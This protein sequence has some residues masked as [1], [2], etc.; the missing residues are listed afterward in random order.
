MDSGG[1]TGLLRALSS[2][3]NLQRRKEHSLPGQP[4]PL[5]D[6][7][8]EWKN[9]SL[10]LIWTSLFILHTHPY[11]AL[12]I[13]WICLLDGFSLA[14]GWLLLG[15]PKDVPLPGRTSL[16][17]QPLPK[18]QVIQSPDFLGNL[19]PYSLQFIS[20]FPVLRCLKQRLPIPDV[21][22]QVLR[23]GSW[24]LPWIY[25]LSYYKYSP[26]YFGVF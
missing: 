17:Q 1:Q 19:L 11:A 22:Q 16:V 13:A 21:N 23:R 4:L 25:C 26:G 10:Y 15:S 18:M 12:W 7:S 8:L 6:L 24:P 9:F 5:P 3:V 2:L 14:T 20:I